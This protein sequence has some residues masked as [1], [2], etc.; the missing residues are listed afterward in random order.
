MAAPT[1]ASGVIALLGLGE[2]GYELAKGWRA[3][4]QPPM[5]VAFDRDAPVSGGTG[6]AAGSRAALILQRAQETGVKLCHSAFEAVTQSGVD[7]V[8]SAVTAAGASAVIEAAGM[9]LAG[10]TFV[11]V[12][13]M[14]PPKKRALGEKVAARGGRFVDAA[15]VGRFAV[16]GVHV[17]ML[18]SGPGSAALA[19]AAPALGLN[20]KVVGQIPGE[21]SAIKMF[22]SI[23]QK[24]LDSLI[25]ELATAASAYGVLDQVMSTLDEPGRPFAR[26]VD[27]RLAGAALHA[28][29]RSEEMAD[30]V[31]FLTEIGADATMARAERDKLAGIAALGLDHRFGGQGAGGR[32]EI[33]AALAEV[34][35]NP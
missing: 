7:L 25:W 10:K 31:D 12:N 18:L 13:T 29:R 6:P 35:K 30:V 15:V 14:S 20:V 11:D 22:R 19:E 17:P 9:G 16:D 3:L 5:V 32:A 21:A 24:G 2:A 33:L 26:L 8:F 1:S 27:Y 23:Y 34:R 4:P 28:A